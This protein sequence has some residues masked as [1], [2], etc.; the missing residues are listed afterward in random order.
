[1]VAPSQQGLVVDGLTPAVQGYVTHPDDVA[2]LVSQHGRYHGLVKGLYDEVCGQRKGLA[3]QLHSFSPRSVGISKTDEKIVEALHAAY[4]PEVYATWPERPAIDLISATEDGTFR[5]APELM[6]A[7][8][9]AYLAAGIAA[10]QNATYHLHP[11]TMGYVYAHA[12]PRQVLC[13]EMNRGLICD[14]FVPFGV[15]PIATVELERMVRPIAQILSTA[16]LA[17][18]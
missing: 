4:V 7:L 11:V 12:H 3:L 9:A 16:L 15:S 17:R 10:K 13:V 1:V 5:T 14:P 18:P 2:W 8:Q 6:D